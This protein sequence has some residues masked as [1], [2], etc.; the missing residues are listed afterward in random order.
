MQALILNHQLSPQRGRAFQ[1]VELVF[2]EVG[3]PGKL[4]RKKH[5]EQG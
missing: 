3:K 5:P 2:D 1:Q 4:E